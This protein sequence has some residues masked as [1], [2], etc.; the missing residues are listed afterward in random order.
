VKFGTKE[1]PL[2]FPGD[3]MSLPI[4]ESRYCRP[5]IGESNKFLLG[6]L[7]NQSFNSPLRLWPWSIRSILSTSKKAAPDIYHSPLLII[8]VDGNHPVFEHFSIL[9][10][11]LARFIYYRAF[12]ILVKMQIEFF[13]VRVFLGIV[14]ISTNTK[15]NRTNI[16]LFTFVID[17][18]NADNYSIVPNFTKADKE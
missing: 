17:F 2:N 18:T 3:F 7:I 12:G 10:G 14:I 6:V 16:L 11:S 4:K 13:K 5:I 9:S 1:N 8:H 15:K